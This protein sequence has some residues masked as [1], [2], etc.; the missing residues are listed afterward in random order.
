MDTPTPRPQ[1]GITLVVEY[2]GEFA[3]QSTTGSS[4][5]I[6][7]RG[8]LSDNYSK[9]MENVQLP[10]HWRARK[11]DGGVNPLVLKI[12]YEGQVVAEDTAIGEDDEAW[13]YWE[14]PQ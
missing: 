2:D 9:V 1:I 12:I 14:G 13:V 8:V 7:W 6:S 11:H 3:Y 10:R 4:W 5:G